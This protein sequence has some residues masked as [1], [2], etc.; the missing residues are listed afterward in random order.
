MSMLDIA[1]AYIAQ[2]MSVLPVP[3]KMKKP[4]GDD[5]QTL[6]ITAV[7]APLF[8]NGREMNIGVLMGEPSNGLTDVDLDSVEAIRA[9]PYLLPPSAT[10]GHSPSKPGSHYLYR[11]DLFATQTRAVIKLMSSDKRGILEV[12]MGGGGLG[13]QTI[14]PGSTHVSGEAIQWEDSG[15]LGK[16]AKVDGAELL[17]HCH[18]LAAAAEL[19][20]FYPQEGRRHG[21]AFVLGGFLARAGFGAPEA[22]LFAEAIGAASDQPPE[23]R[24]DMKRTA[25]DGAEAEKKAGYPQLAETFGEATAKKVAKWLEYESAEG[26]QSDKGA[27]PGEDEEPRKIIRATPFAWL[28][29]AK[30]P[31]RRWLYGHHYAREFISQTVAFGGVGK[32]NLAIVEQLAIVTGRDLLGVRPDERCKTWYWNGEDPIDELNRRI[33]AAAL[34]YKIERA[35]IEGRLFYDTGRSTRIIIAEQTKTGAKIARPVVADIIAAIRERNIGLMTI[36]PFVSC[37][38]VTE[39]DNAAMEAVASAWAEIADVTKCSIEFIHHSR[40]TGGAE[41]TVEDGRGAS[42]VLAKARAARVLN[43]MDKDEAARAGVKDPR[44]FFKVANGKLNNAPPPANVADWYEI[45]SFDLANGPGGFSGDSVGVVNTWAWPNP[46]QDVT[47]ADLRAA[48]AAI[49]AGRWRE[50]SQA[51]DWAGIAIAG[52]L[53]LDPRDMAAK[54]KIAGLLKVWIANGM[55]VVVEALDEKRM[56]K[57]FVEVGEAASD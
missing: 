7:D 4:I 28:E 2:G 48:Q 57:L 13:A 1:L 51:K 31:R 45:R 27:E 9:A 23:K 15:A 41:V 18:R 49:R 34:H 44:L 56:K 11:S 29:P 38:T 26:E 14:F 30:I 12:R 46:L 35:E 37:H 43:T 25:R 24:R 36:D 6:R 33:M 47:V 53:R 40:K 32:S 17:K 52:V 39:N 54:A 55:F 21:A 20:M 22:A 5:W 8:F 50:N 42:A 16:I 10:F 3:H 19:A